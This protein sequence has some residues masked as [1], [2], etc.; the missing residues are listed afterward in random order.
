MLK[1]LWLSVMLRHIARVIGERARANRR[2]WGG[3]TICGVVFS[4]QKIVRM[5]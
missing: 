2:M 4:R 5:N 1:S 3:R